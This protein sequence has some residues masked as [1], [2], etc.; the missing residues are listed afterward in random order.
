[1]DKWTKNIYIHENKSIYEYIDKYIIV[2][3]YCPTLAYSDQ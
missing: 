3:K 2:F 1:M